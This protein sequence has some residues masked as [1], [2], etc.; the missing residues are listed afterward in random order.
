MLNYRTSFLIIMI[1]MLPIIFTAQTLNK[2]IPSIGDSVEYYNI[3]SINLEQ[4]IWE[5]KGEG[6]IWDFSELSTM[7]PF[8]KKLITPEGHAGAQS[9]PEANAVEVNI[10]LDNIAIYYKIYPDSIV[11]LG[12]RTN[13]YTVK[14]DEPPTI[15]KHPL[16][17]NQSF[18]CPISIKNVFTGSHTYVFDGIGTLH[19]PD[20]TYN[21]AYRVSY[22][23]VYASGSNKDTIKF[24]TFY[25]N[26]GGA[27]IAMFVNTLGS[28]E[29]HWGVT[30]RNDI[31]SSVTERNN[32]NLVYI[33]K[34]RLC[35]KDA[36][37]IKNIEIYDLLGRL[38]DRYLYI[39]S[40]KIDVSHLERG[41]YIIKVENSEGYSTFIF[42]N[43]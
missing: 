12:Y 22:L 20:R 6:Q 9:F 8:T 34:G 21:N 42:I 14:Y 39:D 23:D 5:M 10:G 28:P 27:A 32:N 31:P 19:L 7:Q 1:G 3:E 13:N 16:E 2:I 4:D 43:E 11:Q 25:E 38:A 33:S 35:F 24:V 30:F 26:I 17:Y 41:I 37:D 36:S 18:L 40:D 15:I 29:G